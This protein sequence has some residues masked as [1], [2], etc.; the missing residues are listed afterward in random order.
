MTRFTRRDGLSVLRLRAGS[1]AVL[2][3][4]ATGLR[5]RARRHAARAS[6]QGFLARIWDEDPSGLRNRRSRQARHR[7]RHRHRLGCRAATCLRSFRHTSRCPRIRPS[8]TASPLRHQ[9]IA[10]CWPRWLPSRT[11]PTRRFVRTRSARAPRAD[12]SKYRPADPRRQRRHHRSCPARAGLPRLRGAGRRATRAGWRMW[13]PRTR[14]P[15]PPESAPLS[16]AH[17]SGRLWQSVPERSELG[18]KTVWLRSGSQQRACS[19]WPWQA[20]GLPA[21]H[22]SRHRSRC[23]WPVS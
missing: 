6:H 23:R 4:A 10:C 19:A 7:H 20:G 22:L 11:R 2:R 17:M 15:S 14:A 21:P 5:A 1:E 12:P 16:P 8:L 18:Q 9:S 13:S 3:A